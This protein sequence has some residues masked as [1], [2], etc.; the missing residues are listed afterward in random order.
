MNNV[1]FWIRRA[2]TPICPHCNNGTRETTL[3][4]LLFCPHYNTAR[5]SILAATQREKNPIVFLMGDRKGIPH[6]L[7]Y[8][9]DT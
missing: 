9:H 5:H 6:L 4:F 7:R 3:H 2:D 8:V 1:L